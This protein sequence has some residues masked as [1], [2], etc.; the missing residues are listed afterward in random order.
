MTACP[1]QDGLAGEWGSQ[2]TF[3]LFFLVQ[4]AFILPP[5][6]R[7]QQPPLIPIPGE[8]CHPKSCWI[9]DGTGRLN[10]VLKL[11]LLFILMYLSSKKFSAKTSQDYYNEG[12]HSWQF[13]MP[14]FS[15]KVLFFR[16]V[17]TLSMNFWFII[18][19]YQ[20]GTLGRMIGH[21]SAQEFT[22]A[23]LQW[24]Q[25]VIAHSKAMEFYRFIPA[26]FIQCLSVCLPVSPSI[27]KTHL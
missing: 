6:V 16:T 12:N 20:T 26:G 5:A 24:R 18:V 19:M 9:A 1:W 7:K 15:S 3:F 14:H 23:D 10:I 25:T 17:Y 2:L 11:I 4:M 13:C 27:H 22:G 21:M 8:A